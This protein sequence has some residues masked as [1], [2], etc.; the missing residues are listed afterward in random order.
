MNRNRSTKAGRSMISQ[1]GVVH[2]HLGQNCPSGVFQ[3]KLTAV[4]IQSSDAALVDHKPQLKVD[5][6]T[7][8]PYS[9]SCARTFDYPVNSSS[10]GQFWRRGVRFVD[11]LEARR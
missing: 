1:A 5:E 8:K 2:L 9:A 11:W 4:G 10:R 6:K 7:A 3:F